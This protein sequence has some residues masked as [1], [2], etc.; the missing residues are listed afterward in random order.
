MNRQIVSI[1]A[2]AATAVAA[3]PSMK[4]EPFAKTS[5]GQT[6]ERFTLTNRNGMIARF[7]TW[8]ANLTELH[9]PD[10]EGKMADVTLGFDDPQR[11]LQPHPFFGCIAGRFANRIARGK[12]TL[13]GK[14][15]TLATNNGPNHLHGGKVGFDKRNWQPEPVSD[16]AVRFRYTSPD[17]EEGYPGKLEVAITYTLTDDN[18]LRLDYEATTDAPTVLN[19]TNHSYFNLASTPDILGHELMLNA[20]RYT[21]VDATSIPTGELPGVDK[22]MDF[23]TAKLIGRDIAG[24]KDAP[25]GGYDHNWV[26]EGWKPGQLALAA[27]LRDPASGRTMKVKTTEPGIQFYSANYVKDVAGKGGRT[28]GKH[29][30]LCLET[31]HFPDSP[32]QPTFP[33]TVLRPGEKFQS[34]T[35]FEFTAK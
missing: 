22:T 16:N 17:G 1:L 14:T 12:F 21:E 26:I 33:S 2:I 8:G 29:A 31:Q 24:L 32:N 15:Y 6:V 35:I 25:G 9:V 4:R 10:R 19:L 11:W 7:I 23:S 34:T 30:G 20:K 13:D 18:T 28:Y 3:E 5:D 27:E